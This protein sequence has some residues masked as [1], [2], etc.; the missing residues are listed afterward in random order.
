M[1]ILATES[2]KTPDLPAT[3]VLADVTAEARERLAASGR[4]VEKRLGDYL[5]VQGQAHRELALILSGRVAVSAHAHGDRVDLAVLGAGD[6]VGEMGIIDPRPAS[7]TARVAAGPARVWLIDGDSFDRFVAADPASGFALMRALA[8]VL[9]RRV[10][11][12]SEHM[13]RKASELK[14]HFLDMDY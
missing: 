4:F 3:G 14:A 12:D 8:R 11:S 7:A 10:R 1:S 9:C 6:V 5:T 2:L 13:L